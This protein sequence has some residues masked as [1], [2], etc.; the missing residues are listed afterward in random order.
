MSRP[1]CPAWRQR[2]CG[3]GLG[4]GF[5]SEPALQPGAGGGAWD[6]AA[7]RQFCD[8]LIS[9]IFVNICTVVASRPCCF[10]VRPLR[11]RPPCE[12]EGSG[13]RLRGR[14][15]GR[16]SGALR[17]VEKTWFPLELEMFRLAPVVSFDSDADFCLATKWL[18]SSGSAAN[19]PTCPRCQP[20]DYTKCLSPAA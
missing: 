15:G 8:F 18:H 1:G 6:A 17:L 5:L 10:R 7:S 14:E 19:L 12:A 16:G 20:V 11:A 3:C 13:G 2:T 9:S 4:P